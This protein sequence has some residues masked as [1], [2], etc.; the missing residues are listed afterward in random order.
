MNKIR[1]LLADDQVLFAECLKN[2]LETRTKD[3]Q[4]VGIAHNGSEAIKMA[5]EL[6]PDIVL[7]DAR[8][9]VLDGVGAARMIHEKFPAIKIIMLTAFDDEYA[10][11]ALCYGAWAY[12]LKD[13]SPCE[14]IAALRA[15]KESPEIVSPSITANTAKI[16]QVREAQK[17]KT[18]GNIYNLSR[19][20][21]EVLELLSQGLNNK[22]IAARI[23]LAEQTVKNILSSIYSKTG[24]HYRI[25]ALKLTMYPGAD[26]MR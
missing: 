11:K 26:S 23:F 13:V 12:L 18:G 2:L 20:E 19:R 1:I 24:A 4:V 21:R 16:P 10:R 7:M 6:S 8:M 15:A 3:I 25:T 14:V 9:P 5:R 22:E 17:N